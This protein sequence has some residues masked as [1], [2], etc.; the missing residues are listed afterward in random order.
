[1]SLETGTD[2]AHQGPVVVTEEVSTKDGL[3]EDTA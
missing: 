2:C 3:K 1:M